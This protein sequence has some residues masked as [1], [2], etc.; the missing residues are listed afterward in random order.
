M[1]KS[2]KIFFAAWL[3][4]L[5]PVLVLGLSGCGNN[6]SNGNDAEKK[7]LY[8]QGLEVV[9]LMSEMAGSEEYMELYTENSGVTSV[10]Q[11]ISA[12]DYTTPK[13]VYAISVTEEA[14]ALMTEFVPLENISEE[15]K[16]FLMQRILNTLF[17]QIN[18]L[19]GVE[20][21]AA[22][23]VCAVEKVFV[24]EDTKKDVVYLYTYDNA[25]PV[26]VTFTVGEDGAILAK[27][28]FVLYDGF[29]CGSADE[30]K[31]FFHDVI[32]EVTEVFPEK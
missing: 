2:G 3:V 11:G 13:A 31:A 30:I 19:G 23:S 24:H 32:V 27:G 1:K 4:I 26:A 28:A 5:L 22:S 29:T 15:L 8:A 12:G 21:I 18:A 7:S 16:T 20:D 17:T 25:T 9:R 14:L 10:V 6:R